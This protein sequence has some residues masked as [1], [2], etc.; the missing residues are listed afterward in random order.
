M[1]KLAQLETP[2]ISKQ[3]QKTHGYILDRE[4]FEACSFVKY[5]TFAWGE[6]KGETDIE[7]KMGFLLCVQQREMTILEAN[8]EYRRW[9]RT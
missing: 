7:E 5:R 1:D 2:S 3:H 4:E 8:V 6:R 9:R